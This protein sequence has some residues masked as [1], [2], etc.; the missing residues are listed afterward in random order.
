MTCNNS[1][2]LCAVQSISY[3]ILHITFKVRSQ[4]ILYF[5]LIYIPHCCLVVDHSESQ[6]INLHE[7][8]SLSDFD[9]FERTRKQVVV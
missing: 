6:Q 9:K 5:R 3:D 4:E 2:N 8:I 7:L 1:K